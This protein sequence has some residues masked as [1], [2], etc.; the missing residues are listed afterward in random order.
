L[1]KESE[2]LAPTSTAYPMT[3]A[4][5]RRTPRHWRATQRPRRGPVL[6]RRRRRRVGGGPRHCRH[7]IAGTGC[8]EGAGGGGSRGRTT[9]RRVPRTARTTTG[10]V[11]VEIGPEGWTP[12]QQPPGFSPSLR[13]LPRGYYF[14][15]R[16]EGKCK[17]LT[18]Q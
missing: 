18:T 6:L 16:K 15:L 12:T 10:A 1:T 4:L 7:G 5:L 8:G 9:R 2:V 3:R 13:L 11:L 17:N 14:Y